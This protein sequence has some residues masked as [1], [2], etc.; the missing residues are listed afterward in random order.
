MGPPAPPP[1][2]HLG[3]VLNAPYPTLPGSTQTGG[4]TTPN[5]PA[6]SGAHF[7]PLALDSRVSLRISFTLIHSLKSF[8]PVI[9]PPG[10]FAGSYYLLSLFFSFTTDPFFSFTRVSIHSLAIYPLSLHSSVTCC[11]HPSHTTSFTASFILPGFQPSTVH[12]HTTR[13]FYTHHQS[14]HVLLPPFFPSGRVY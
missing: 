11:L 14:H 8:A 5:Q 4:P 9:Y 3:G 12:T 6:P 7:H 13:Q 1:P 2:S 10:S